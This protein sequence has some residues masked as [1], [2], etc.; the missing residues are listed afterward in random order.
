[1]FTPKQYHEKQTLKTVAFETT[2]VVFGF[3]E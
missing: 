3:D 2:L 1:M